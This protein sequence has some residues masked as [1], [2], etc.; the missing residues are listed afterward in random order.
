MESKCLMV[1]SS[2]SKMSR[3]NTITIEYVIALNMTGF[4]VQIEAMLAMSQI[5]E[6][7]NRKYNKGI[8]SMNLLVEA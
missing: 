5:K 2:T 7:F 8:F 3:I 4:L 1:S 6:T